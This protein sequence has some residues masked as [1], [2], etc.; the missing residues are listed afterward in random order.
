MSP[1]VYSPPKAK[2]VCIFLMQSK[3][4][5]RCSLRISDTVQIRNDLLFKLVFICR[6]NDAETISA[7]Q[8][9]KDAIGTLLN[10]SCFAQSIAGMSLPFSSFSITV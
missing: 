9:D 10:G 8:I 7:F 2:Q 1:E 5:T 3:T 4:T 6:I